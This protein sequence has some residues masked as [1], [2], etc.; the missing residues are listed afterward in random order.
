MYKTVVKVCMIRMTRCV[1]QRQA[2]VARSAMVTV[3][4]TERRLL[5]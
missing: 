1:F 5:V 4:G 3:Y 2:D